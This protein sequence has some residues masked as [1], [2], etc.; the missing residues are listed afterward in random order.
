MSRFL[1]PCV[2]IFVLRLA[3][4]QS[5]G[6]IPAFP[7]AE[8]FGSMA[9]GGRGGDVYTVSNLNASGSGSFAE[10]VAT[11]PAQGRTI[12]FAVSGHIRLPSGSGGGLTINKNKI[13][14]A[15]QTAPGDGIC[16][17]NNTMNLTGN[18]MVVRHI[19]WRYGKQTAGGD[20][21]DIANAQRII[22][23]HCDVMFSTDENISSFGTPPEFFTFQW[24]VNAW[25]LNSHS[26]GGLWDIN[27]ATAHHTL[28]ANNHTRNP[29]C[30]S[31]SV[32][33]W[34]N[35]VTFGWNNG[36]NMAASTDPIARVNIRGS[37]F[38]H[39]GGTTS[40]IYGGGLNE[41]GQNIFQLHMSD[42]ALDGSN[43]GILDVTR[44]N[45]AMVNSNQYTQTAN[46]WPQTIDGNPGNP[47]IGTPVTLDSRATA[48]KK[49][50]SKAGAVRMEIGDRPLRDEITTLRVNRVVAMQRGIISDPLELGLTT[51]TAFASLQSAPAP[52]DTDL[53]GMPDDFEDAV[54]Y[55][56]N[57]KD[58][59]IAL[60]APQT[61]ASF[62]PAG[63]P[64]GYTRLEEYLHFK[65]VPHGT[66]AR[67]TISSPS[68]IDMD[69]RKFTSGFPTGPVFT[70]SGIS[71]GTTS[72]SGP[73]NAIVRFTPNQDF[74]GR[75]GFLFTVTDAAGDSWTQQC[76]LLVSTRT[77]PRPVT[78]EGDGVSNQ[79]DIATAN[80]RTVAGPTAFANGDAVTIG[81]NGSNSPNLQ[82]SGA[83]APS[84]LV[85]S[86]TT[87]NFT[88]AGGGSL[89]GTG[90]LAKSG[91]GTLTISNAG[92]NSFGSTVL[93]EGT[94]SFTTPIALGTGP[95]T[96]R[97]GTLAFSAD[98]PNAL[99]FAGPVALNPSGNRNLGGAWTGSG[100]VRI[101]NT[102]GS[103][104]TLQGNTSAFTGNVDFAASSGSARFFGSIGSAN[105]AF[106]LG[107]NN[108]TLYTRNGGPSFQLGSL[109][110][111]ANTVLSGASSSANVTTY[112]IGALNTS[113]VFSG[114][115]TDG[116][117]GA[118][119][120]N[121]TGTGNLTLLGQST[122]SGATNIN[123]GKLELL[124]GFGGSAVTVADNATLT[125]DGTLGGSLTTVAGA[126]ISPGA[127]NGSAAGILTVGSVNLASTSLLFD[128]S[129]NPSSGNDRI[130]ISN[131]GAITLNGTLN[132]AFNRSDGYLSPGTYNL[133]TTSGPLNTSGVTLASNL[134]NDTRQSFGLQ[135]AAHGSSPGYVRLVVSGGNA[136]LTWTGAEGALWNR[137]TTAAWSGA[138]PATFYNHDNVLFDDT[139]STGV[140]TITQPVAPQSIVVNNA[141]LPY[142]ITG[143]AIN[144]TTAL[145]KSGGGTLTLNV[146]QYTLANSTTTNGSATVAVS[147]TANL[148]PGMTVTG[149]GI[150]AGT[151][152]QAIPSSTTLT[153]SKTASAGSSTVTLTINTR[154]T[155]SGGTFLH[156]G[157][158]VLTSNAVPTSG[159]IPAPANPFGL[160]TG[161]ISFHGGSLYL[162]GNLGNLSGIHGALPNDIIVPAG[163]T[164]HLF[165]TVRGLNSAPFASL[166]GS[167]TGSGTLNLT[168]NYYRSAITGD[169]SGF[170]GVIHVKRPA[171][172]ASDP[173]IQFGGT[174]GLPLAT[175]NLEHVRMEYTA[176]PPAEG[177]TIP[178]GSLS[179]PSNA[180]ISGSQNAAG[181]V[182]WRIGGLN[183][184]TTFAGSF[185][186]FN[187][188]PIGL[189][190]IGSGTLTLTGTGTLNAGISVEEGT[191]SY[192]DAPSDTLGGGGEISISPGAVLQLNGGATLAGAFCEVF[193]GGRLGGFGT[194]Q[195]HLG[196]IGTIL[197]AGGTLAISGDAEVG[198][199]LA[200]SSLTDRLAVA[201]H[202]DLSGAIQ[203]PATGLSTGRHPLVAYS[204]TLGGLGPVLATPP[205]AY[206][207]RIDTA[208]P[209]EVAVHLIDRAGYE[210]WQTGNFGN[211][212][213]P[214]AQPGADP[215]GDGSTN[216]QEYENGTNPNDH[217]PRVLTVSSNNPALTFSSLHSAYTNG[218]LAWTDG[219][220]LSDRA[221]ARLILDTTLD[222]GTIDMGAS[223]NTLNI[224]SGGIDFL[225]PNHLTLTGGRIGINGTAVTINTGGT[226]TLSLGSPI[227]GGTG[228]LSILGTSRVVLN[229][230][231]TFT[232]GLTLDGATLVQGVAGALGAAGGNLTI[233]SGVLDLNGINAS[234]GILS[235]SGGQITS[236]SPA[237]LAFGTN[238]ASGGNFAGSISGGVA[239]SRVGGNSSGTATLSGSNSY[240]GATNL[241]ANSGTLVLANDNSL[242]N[243]PSVICSGTGTSVALADGITITGKP[244]TIRGSGANNGTTG[245]FSG[246]LTTTSNA[247]AAWNGAVT[248]G[249]AGARIGAG[250]NGSLTVSGAIAGSGT[251]Q[252]I[253]FSSG[254]GTSLGTVVLSGPNSF[255]GNISIVRGSLK[256]GAS[257]T[258][259]AT[260]IID[261]G[262]ANVVENT[263]FDL[264]GFSQ[265]IA[266][267]RRTSNNST[268]ISTVTNSSNTPSTLA[269]NQSS[270][271]IYSGRITGAL[272]L[273]KSGGGT[274]TL[275]RGDALAATLSVLLD[276]GAISISSAHTISSL[277][278]DG[279]WM[280][281]GT[282]NAANA[283]GRIVGTGSLVVTS[284]GPIGFASWIDGFTT[285]TAGQKFPTADPDNDGINNLLEYVLNGTPT[286]ANAAILPVATRDS[287]HLIF[288]FTQRVESHATT[289]QVLEYGGDL[290]GWTPVNITTPTAPEVSFGPVSSGFRTV[291]VSIPIVS[292]PNGRLFG[293]LRAWS[294]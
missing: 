22:L 229:A 107:S 52:V 245:N 254:T 109:S 133:I 65:A 244:I 262:S 137:Q 248:I 276:G 49:V 243:T 37:W 168:V 182:I 50:I 164:G 13:T 288:T 140:V 11:A 257:G 114:R 144:G 82:I 255:T 210:A 183:T 149:N 3:V 38:I 274:L 129:A 132:F 249:D 61:A 91:G 283:S 55:D 194:L 92:P 138:S 211:T 209:G 202:L 263:T 216:F 68:F 67:N 105:A 36:F 47:L 125:G 28:W 84:S 34:T 190:K 31:P 108:F 14:I 59:N 196:S 20:A 204:G 222:A 227:S 29:K 96:L 242:G 42:S 264:G 27:H 172:G 271:L 279:A 166:T 122:H 191:L 74:S 121:K 54:G 40:A 272:T 179:G 266:G 181:S 286:L 217:L 197:V 141:S 176:A 86:N 281:P 260:A 19:R 241:A 124:G 8:G 273:A 153:L 33:D 189:E 95:V 225:G 212:T 219:G 66:V 103:L 285:L 83:L 175:L 72:Q 205:A 44:V 63:S 157:A 251:N 126:A 261:V 145:V 77:L 221:V 142:T 80:F 104:L 120:I 265:A 159:G 111:G 269:L 247:T 102:G 231:S 69:L 287:T 161:P 46:A 78:W 118:T 258:L 16:F 208:T 232:G 73:G 94:L 290:T 60:T 213:D 256:L 230:V 113:S 186:P 24:S 200:F 154:N 128:L 292:A 87:K 35:N 206:L 180:V 48:Y 146:P 41:S 187:N 75:G 53:D 291:T 26:C 51:G 58:H 151:V 4:A 198:G 15:G 234:P 226:A 275:T 150:P 99:V 203:L 162:H 170:T 165:D 1:T 32:F 152:I 85:V 116:G 178:I 195:A 246:A 223:S 224:V 127:D 106:D 267:L 139:A 101:N 135:R 88:L 250:N 278:L 214:D 62:L 158:L 76:C 7:G 293:R 239:L 134:P 30:I 131:G 160:G 177:I 90:G 259:P 9:S 240:S 163:E 23:D 21:V 199:T 43:N 123:Q 218:V 280:P 236:A 17:W 173:R 56:K 97:G 185:T 174:T 188:Y 270:N 5:P 10:A 117:A 45:H 193:S 277:R 228:S 169:W 148:L 268:Q 18:D 2:L 167:L 110:G 156:D 6:Q 81:D 207:G 253:A 71:N 100:A 282:Y 147:S 155:Y 89:A 112:T 57:T 235:G 233:H 79:W 215:D 130:E 25:G 284:G 39:G 201:G 12:V 192:G 171:S 220:S 184:S 93:D 294:P 237:T 70:L 238:N 289:A 119:A 136:D 143:S 115:F 252:N 64:A 98:L